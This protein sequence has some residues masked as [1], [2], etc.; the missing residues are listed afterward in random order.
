MDV[1]LYYNCD[2]IE[3]AGA[4]SAATMKALPLKVHEDQWSGI[5]KPSHSGIY[6]NRGGT[7]GFL[8]AGEDGYENIISRSLDAMV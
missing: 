5:P 6:I 3:T 7:S 2:K 8:A 1:R 4:K